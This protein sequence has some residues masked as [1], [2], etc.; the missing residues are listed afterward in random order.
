MQV[1]FLYPQK[2]PICAAIYCQQLISKSKTQ[3]ERELCH[4]MSCC[5]ITGGR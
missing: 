3:W 2:Q 5:V 1:E 4:H